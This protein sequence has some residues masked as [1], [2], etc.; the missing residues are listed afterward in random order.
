MN[1]DETGSQK[2][3]LSSEWMSKLMAE[4]AGRYVAITAMYY[5]PNG[6]PTTEELIEVAAANL[7]NL[8]QDPRWQ[9]VYDEIVKIWELEK[10]VTEND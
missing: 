4:A 10:H 3:A 1:G 5:F 9:N 7:K 6:Q 8:A 2:I